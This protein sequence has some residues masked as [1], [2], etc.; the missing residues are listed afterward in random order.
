MQVLLYSIGAFITIFLV[1]ELI[2]NLEES[3]RVSTDI[4]EKAE[5]AATTEIEINE[6]REHY[7]PVATRGSL[8]FFMLSSLVRV[9]KLYQFSPLSF[10]WKNT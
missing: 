2:E 7:R 4:A 10:I 1:V 6:A 3:K 5:I 8:L 9:S